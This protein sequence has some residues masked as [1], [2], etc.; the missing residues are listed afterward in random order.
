MAT[1]HGFP[2]LPTEIRL[3]IWNHYAQPDLGDPPRIVELGLKTSPCD[4][5]HPR[6]SYAFRRTYHQ[7]YVCREARMV[8]DIYYRKTFVCPHLSHPN[9]IGHFAWLNFDTDVVR[10]SLLHVGKTGGADRHLIQRLELISN[11]LDANYFLDFG[12]RHLNFRSLKS[13]D[14]LHDGSMREWY[15]QVAD[16]PWGCDTSIMRV[17]HKQS[18]EVLDHDRDLE[19][20]ESGIWPVS[21]QAL[22]VD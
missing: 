3:L 10:M 20:S 22:S 1:F 4:P 5:G 15:T 17:I 7:F 18:G 21:K 14:I 9:H 19:I 12:P 11:D 13:I 16:Q 6:C 8:G 2:D